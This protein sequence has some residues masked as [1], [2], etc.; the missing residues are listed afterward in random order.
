MSRSGHDEEDY[1]EDEDLVRGSDFQEESP[2]EIERT[3]RRLSRQAQTPAKKKLWVLVFFLEENEHSPPIP[4]EEVKIKSGHKGMEA[5]LE[6]YEKCK[7]QYDVVGNMRKAFIVSWSENEEE[8]EEKYEKMKEALKRAQTLDE[9]ERKGKVSTIVKAVGV[10]VVAGFLSVVA[11]PLALTAAGF[12]AGGI[13]AG[14]IAAQ[15]MSMSAIASGGGVMAGG[16]IATLQSAGAAGIAASTSLGIGVGAGTV[17]GAVTYLSSGKSGSEE[18][19][20][21]KCKICLDCEI[22]TQF[23][24]C[25]HQCTCRSCA[26]MLQKCPI[27]RKPIEKRAK[28][29]KEEAAGN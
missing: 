19:A 16:L 20:E 29:S 5:G 6:K 15:A 10:G 17:G 23:E 22:D 27:C 24:P 9:E 1:D 25:G 8:L 21:N 7:A 18:D 13:A 2:N 11:A 14:S 26:S 3:E 28:K 4:L 12:T